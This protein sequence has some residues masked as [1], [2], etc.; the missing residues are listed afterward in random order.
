MDSTHPLQVQPESRPAAAG[1]VGDAREG[2]PT[3]D[4]GTTPRL[5]IR[6]RITI[7][8][9]TDVAFATAVREILQEVRMSPEIEFGNG[10]GSV[11]AQRLLR[12]RGYAHARVVD[13]RDI[14]EAMRRT[15]HWLVLRDG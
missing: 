5:D 4:T 12:T 6:A 7:T 15:A 11:L 13:A 3:G 9:W 1:S 14:D 2:S 10:G 8:P